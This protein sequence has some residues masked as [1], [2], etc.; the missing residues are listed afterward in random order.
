MKPRRP[1][2]HDHSA[3]FPWLQLCPC[4]AVELHS[5]LLFRP[6][7]RNW[8]LCLLFDEFQPPR[9]SRMKPRLTFPSGVC[10]GPVSDERMKPI[11]KK[12]GIKWPQVWV[13]C[14]SGSLV[15]R[16]HYLW[17]C[18]CNL[19][20]ACD[21]IKE[22]KEFRWW[23]SQ[24]LITCDSDAFLCISEWKRNKNPKELI[25]ENYLEAALR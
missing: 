22:H 13:L 19:Q 16:R 11:D 10:M 21:N 20:W 24:D 7:K 2:V 17:F 3:V 1:R 4:L 23:N 6:K 14:E 12:M 18:P 15:I 5:D 9:E 8:C 25:R